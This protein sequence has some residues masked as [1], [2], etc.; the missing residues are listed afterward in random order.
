MLVT[1]EC[2]KVELPSESTGDIKHNC[3][4]NESCDSL[5]RSLRAILQRE[6]EG[7]GLLV[8]HTGAGSSAET[9]A[10]F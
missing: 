10:W 2:C 6:V 8:A 9:F 1:F 7:Y 4:T 3:L 5:V